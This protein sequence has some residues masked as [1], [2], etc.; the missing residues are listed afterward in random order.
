[1]F[2]DGCREVARDVEG[3]DWGRGLSMSR[4]RCTGLGS[5]TFNPPQHFLNIDPQ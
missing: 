1:M 2:A 4:K 3:H 5:R